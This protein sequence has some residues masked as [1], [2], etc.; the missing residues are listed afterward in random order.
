MQ[1]HDPH[2]R[3]LF[4]NLRVRPLPDALPA[5]PVEL[6]LG[7]AEYRRLLTLHSENIPVIDLHAHLK[8]GLTIEDVLE[9]FYRTGINY[10]IAVNGG[11]GFPITNDAGIYAFRQSLA[12]YP[13]FVALQA[14]GR[15]WLRLFSPEAVRQFDYVFTDAMTFTDDAGRRTRLWM[16]NEVWVDERRCFHGYA[17]SGGSSKSSTTNR[18]IST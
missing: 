18:S 13:V 3:V 9:R 15:E 12:G 4:R 5:E 16:K 11:V 7:E 1:C 6:I 8:G 2:S 10:G 14:E 17:T